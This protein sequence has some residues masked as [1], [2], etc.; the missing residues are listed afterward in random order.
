MKFHA[1]LSILSQYLMSI[2]SVA[3]TMLVVKDG[4]EEGSICSQVA[5]CAMH[6]TDY[7]V[8]ITYDL[9]HQFLPYPSKLLAFI[10]IFLLI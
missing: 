2:H 7:M 9:S 5:A 3:T 4:V 8:Y 1:P 6:K 10:G